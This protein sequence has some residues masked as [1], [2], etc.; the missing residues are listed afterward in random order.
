MLS[1]R[2][3]SENNTAEVTVHIYNCRFDQPYTSGNTENAAI[4]AKCKYGI[5]N[6]ADGV[7]Q[8]VVSASSLLVST[9]QNGKLYVTNYTN[10]DRILKIVTYIGEKAVTIPKSSTY[11]GNHTQEFSEYPAGASWVKCYENDNL[12]RTQKL[13]E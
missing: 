4:F 9:V 2:K 7:E 3:Q 1:R 13:G 6:I 10:N 8:N 5:A 11:D 12:I